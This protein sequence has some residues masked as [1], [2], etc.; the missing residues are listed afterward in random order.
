MEK[1]KAWPDLL[2]EHRD[3][4]VAASTGDIQVSDIVYNTL[5]GMLGGLCYKWERKYTK[6]CQNR[7]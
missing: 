3:A 6:G 2:R 7:E 1:H 5:G 4:A